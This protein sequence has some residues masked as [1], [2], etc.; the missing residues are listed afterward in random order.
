[1]YLVGAVIAPGGGFSANTASSVSFAASRTLPKKRAQ[2]MQKK[3][4]R[5]RS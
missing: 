2:P 4:G 5:G 1:M 3:D